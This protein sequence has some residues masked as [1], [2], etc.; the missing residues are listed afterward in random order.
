MGVCVTLWYYYVLQLRLLFRRTVVIISLFALDQKQ[1]KKQKSSNTLID[2]QGEGEKQMRL[3]T[4]SVMSFLML[5]LQSD[6]LR[7]SY[8]NDHMKAEWEFQQLTDCY[9]G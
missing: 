4:Y 9:L 5:A 2:V 8:F 6:N 7:N 3:F 1:R